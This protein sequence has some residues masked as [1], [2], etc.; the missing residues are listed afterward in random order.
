MRAELDA[1]CTAVATETGRDAHLIEPPA[2]AG[3][4]YYL[5]DPAGF[6]RGEDVPLSGP[7]SVIDGPVR[8]KAIS[9]TPAGAMVDVEEARDALTPAGSPGA[10]TVTG[11]GVTLTFL[12]HEADIVED[13]VI[14]GTNT[15]LATSVD[16][17]QLVSVPDDEGS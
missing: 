9:L 5:V 6:D 11:R 3:T 10:L 16:S 12:R 7:G 17:Y 8:V 14:A 4:R 2:D 1:L 15:R 13:L